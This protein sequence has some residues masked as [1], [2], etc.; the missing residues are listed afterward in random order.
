MDR[1][2]LAQPT[3]KI[4]NLTFEFIYSQGNTVSSIGKTLLSFKSSLIQED[5]TR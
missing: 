5:I 4:S 3:E 2:F 1:H